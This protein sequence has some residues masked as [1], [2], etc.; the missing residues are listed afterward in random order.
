MLT[1]EQAL[2]IV[3][4][5]AR[6]P[7]T[8]RVD[9][10]RALGRVLAEDVKSDMDM[11]PFNKAA[12]DGYACRRQDL[13]N[14]L[15]VIETIP[16]GRPSEKTIGANLCAKIMTGSMVPEG[17]DCVIMKEYVEISGADM[18]RFVGEKTA[19][20]ICVRGEDV[21]AGDVV[22]R[23]GTM[24]RAQHIAVLASVGCVEPAVAKTPRVGVI[25]TGDELVEPAAMPGPSQI[26]NS[27]GFQLAAQVE[28]MGL[29]ASNYGVVRDTA[30]AMDSM[31]RKAFV[32]NE[33]VVVSGG[34]SVGDYANSLWRFGQCLLFWAARQSRVQ[35]CHVRTVGETSSLQDDGTRL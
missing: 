25:A 13:A 23:K 31:F 26:R 4:G 10:S 3:L 20:N 29:A 14:E 11:P 2:E 8:E 16:A 21:K 22:L 28:S 34:V 33:V 7:C 9:I 18:I 1:F 12:M 17:A 5:S 30:V 15:A 19:D 6:E 35:F 27:N 24:L 32:G